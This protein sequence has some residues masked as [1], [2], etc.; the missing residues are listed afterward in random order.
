MGDIFPGELLIGTGKRNHGTGN[1]LQGRGL[2]RPRSLRDDWL[3]GIPH[4]FANSTKAAVQL[5]TNHVMAGK[6]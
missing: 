1:A 6:E 3:E 4:S 5:V 2:I